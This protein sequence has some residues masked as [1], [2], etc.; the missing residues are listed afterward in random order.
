MNKGYACWVVAPS[1]LPHQPGDRVQTDRSD[2]RPLAR[3]AR[4]GALTTV[5]GPKGDEAAIRVLTRAREDALS[6]LK[7]AP[8]RLNAF[9]LRH[10]SR[11]V[12]RAHWGPAPLRWLSAVVCP[13]PA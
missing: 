2:A 11:D 4:S 3:L 10:D 9:W 6:D 8:L 7:D 13:T 12:G 5:Y 1:L